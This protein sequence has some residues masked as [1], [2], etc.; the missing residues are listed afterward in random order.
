MQKLGR[1]TQHDLGPGRPLGRPI[2][3]EKKQV[4]ALAPVCDLS[5]T[6]VEL[7]GQIRLP[8]LELTPCAVVYIERTGVGSGGD[9]RRRRHAREKADFANWRSAPGLDPERGRQLAV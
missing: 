6:A 8:A 7:D 9:R 1:L 5:K 3:G 4:V 2:V